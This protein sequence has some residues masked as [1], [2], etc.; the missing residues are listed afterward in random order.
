MSVNNN[1][2]N[3]L[4]ESLIKKMTN[5]WTDISI[6][7]NGY[8]YRYPGSRKE[9]DKSKK[10]LE[11]IKKL[12]IT[13]KSII[14]RIKN[15]EEKIELRD[16]KYPKYK[17]KVISAIIFF[18]IIAC[19]LYIVATTDTY[20]F[21]EFE[22]DPDLFETNTSCD[23]VWSVDE[24]E[25]ENKNIKTKIRL[26]KGAKLTP[27]AQIDNEWIQVSTLKGQIG[28]VKFTSLAGSNKV[29][30]V[31]KLWA[32]KKVGDD[33]TDTISAGK[34]LTVLD[35]KTQKVNY[36]TNN[37]LK[38]K[39]DDGK[40][41]WVIEEN[42]RYLI[43]E[44]IPE[45][46]P[47][48]EFKTNYSTIKNKVIGDSISGIEKQYGKVT[49]LFNKNNEK[50]V[51]LKHLTVYKND[52]HYDGVVVTIN[53]DNLA[54]S[55]F[56]IEEGSTSGI[57]LPLLKQIRGIEPTRIFNYSFYI[58]NIPE[59]NWWDSFRNYYGWITR[60][61][62]W[63]IK[64]GIIAFILFLFYS[65]GRI[66]AAPFMQLTA[67]TTIL[68]NG[69]VKFVN[70]LL[71]FAFTYMLYLYTVL[72]TDQW[73]FIGI[74]AVGTVQYWYSMHSFTIDYDRCPSCFT[75]FTAM[76]LGT[77]QDGISKHTSTSKEDHYVGTNTTKRGN[78]TYH[79]RNY[80]RLTK[81]TT[82]VYQNYTDNRGCLMCGHEWGI[83]MAK[84]IGSSSKYD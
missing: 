61:I 46:N 76:D 16:H 77:T 44:S 78:T 42:L 7:E 32:Y 56:F 66:L 29:K 19:G 81:R 9:V 60:S 27:I 70:Y 49:S 13:D 33:K 18:M 36:R 3:N 59:L 83:K 57:K 21:T 28:F 80:V 38:V 45:I 23:L 11:Q 84:K 35:R 47:E 14:K 54:D 67:Y 8:E 69:K 68:S 53:S 40:F 4:A 41:R 15:I 64:M 74:L 65:L 52:R 30:S 26:K 71:L 58:N 39:L 12:N 79:T 50:Q 51:F 73:F 37:Y 55:L 31:K 72:I 22:Y 17:S 6:D 1:N 48:F 10:I 62:A 63:V 43:F 5:I 34:V 25:P 75:M 2:S 82:D 24:N 20:N